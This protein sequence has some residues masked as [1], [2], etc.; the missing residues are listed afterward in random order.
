[1]SDDL[2]S[3]GDFDDEMS[4]YLQTFLDETDIQAGRLQNIDV[5]AVSGGAMFAAAVPTFWLGLNLMFVFAVVLG[6][7]AQRLDRL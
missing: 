2:Q 5:L 6:W 3:T 4:E 7:L 1:M